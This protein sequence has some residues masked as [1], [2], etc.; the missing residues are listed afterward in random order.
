MKK[1]LL[2]EECEKALNTIYDTALKFVGYLNIYPLIE[3]IKKN[4]IE[5]DLEDKK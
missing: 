5:E 2:T 3:I 1:I 4:I